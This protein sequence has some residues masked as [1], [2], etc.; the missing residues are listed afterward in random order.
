MGRF[1]D[2]VSLRNFLFLF[3]L[4]L[5]F[6]YAFFLAATK[7]IGAGT[8]AYQ[9]FDVRCGGY[10]LAEAVGVLNQYGTEGRRVYR[11][12]ESTVDLAFPPVY[13]LMFAI[14]IA[15]GVRVTTATLRP[16]ILIPFVAGLFDYAENISV[17]MMINRFPSVAGIVPVASFCTRVK[18]SLLIV[19]MA[20]TLLSGIALLVARFRRGRFTA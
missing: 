9:T 12:L 18:C 8:E 19:S 15:G 17:L 16:L 20:L 1:G 6:K 13:S 14:A 4:S 2:F 11:L 7:R 10:T 5:V 3:V